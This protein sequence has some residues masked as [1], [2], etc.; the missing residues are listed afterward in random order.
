LPRRLISIQTESLREL[1]ASLGED[2]ST[3]LARTHSFSKNCVGRRSREVTVQLELIAKQG[4][5]N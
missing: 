1:L 5:E 3:R 2:A 4:A